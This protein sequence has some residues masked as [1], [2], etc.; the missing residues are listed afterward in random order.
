[1]VAREYN[2]GTIIRGGTGAEP[3]RSECGRRPNEARRARRLG[4]NSGSVRCAIDADLQQRAFS[5]SGRSGDEPSPSPG[6]P[7]EGGG[8][9]DGERRT[10]SDDPKSPSSEP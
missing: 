10:S 8:E 5:R 4:F 9:G 1:M 2:G 6:T 7:G 3:W